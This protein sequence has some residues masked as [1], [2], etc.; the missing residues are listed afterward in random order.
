MNA[1]LPAAL[2][3]GAIRR[4][5]EAT[6]GF[7]AI[8]KRGDPDSGSLILIVEQRGEYRAVVERLLQPGGDYRWEAGGP[9]ASAS[10]KEVS[11]FV[12]KRTR[13]DRDLWLIDLD[14]PDA[15]RFI[16]DLVDAG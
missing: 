9:A 16:A 6:G 11:D 4:S 13:F 10:P 7:A 3:A 8:C 1:R 14:V 2:E 5:V 15:Q 12:E